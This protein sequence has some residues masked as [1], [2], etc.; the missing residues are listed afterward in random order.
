[1]AIT[2]PVKRAPRLFPRPTNPITPS[3][4][5]WRADIAVLR[6]HELPCMLAPA[7]AIEEQRVRHVPNEATGRLS[8]PDDVLL[9]SDNSCG[10]H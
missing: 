9:R 8:R 7:N 3:W 1:M 10:V 2:E 5:D 4:E 6:E